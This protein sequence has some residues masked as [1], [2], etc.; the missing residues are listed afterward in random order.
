MLVC[1]V[2]VNVSVMHGFGTQKVP[3]CPLL[4]VNRDNF[5]YLTKDV[6]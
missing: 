2:S 1:Y 5:F 4:C 3:Y 6:R